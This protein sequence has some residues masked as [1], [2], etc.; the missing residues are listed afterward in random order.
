[1]NKEGYSIPGKDG[2]D[3][4]GQEPMIRGLR[5][6]MESCHTGEITPSRE[7]YLKVMLELSNGAG[8]HSSDIANVLGISRA[9]V[10]CM[11]NVLKR[12]GYVTKEK[13][14]TITLTE[15]GRNVAANVKRRYDL[16]K[17]FFNNVLGVET[18]TAARDACRIEHLISS[19]TTDKISCYLEKKSVYK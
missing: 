18:A 17:E 19:E 1:M 16:L 4:F 15:N 3:P 12:E 2:T 9:S 13:Y 6:M 11:M 10:S 7:D 14:G 5:K 8:V